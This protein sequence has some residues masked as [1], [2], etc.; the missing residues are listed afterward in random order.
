MQ[1]ITTYRSQDKLVE[2]VYLIKCFT[3]SCQGFKDIA[4]LSEDDAFRAL[5]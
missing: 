1:I 4:T 2:L 3:V 5:D